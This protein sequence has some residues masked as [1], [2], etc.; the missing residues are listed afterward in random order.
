MS[1]D[2]KVHSPETDIGKILEA[3]F[4]KM[5]P[6][7]T[8]V[9]RQIVMALNIA[10]VGQ[11]LAKLLQNMQENHAITSSELGICTIAFSKDEKEAYD[12]YVKGRVRRMKERNR[13]TKEGNS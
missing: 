1:G 4:E 6:E 9:A 7:N 3:E 8:G 12:Q 10:N 11:D 13:A 2:L 5:G